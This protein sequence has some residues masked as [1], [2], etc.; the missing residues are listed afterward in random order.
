MA[1]ERRELL[2]SPSTPRRKTP[3]KFEEN[4]GSISSGG[5]LRAVVWGLQGPGAQVR[6]GGHRA[7]GVGIALAKVDTTDEHNLVDKYD[8][9]GF[10]PSF[11]SS[12]GSP[13]HIPTEGLEML[14]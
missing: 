7:Q 14:L 1:P 10:P 4:E 12:T 11:S 8:V 6:R 5:V 9:K 13:F 3:Q 2:L